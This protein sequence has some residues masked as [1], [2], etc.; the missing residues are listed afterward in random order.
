VCEKIGGDKRA[1]YATM[2]QVLK[3][4]S[5]EAKPRFEKMRDDLSK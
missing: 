4:A 5:E 3:L 1:A 2:N